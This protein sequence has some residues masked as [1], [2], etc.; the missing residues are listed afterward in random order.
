MQRLPIAERVWDFKKKKKEMY[1]LHG[2][3]MEGQNSWREF[4]RSEE[5]VKILK[6]H[7]YVMYNV[8]ATCKHEVLYVI[9]YPW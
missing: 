7:I 9:Y 2:Y 6:N 3:N 1:K 5:Y 4:L 8:Y